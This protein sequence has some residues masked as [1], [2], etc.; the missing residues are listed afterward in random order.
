MNSCLHFDPPNGD[1]NLSSKRFALVDAVRGFA[2]ISVL[3]F[4][5]QSGH[6]IDHVMRI[7]PAWLASILQHGYLGVAIFFVLSG[8]VIAHSLY[9]ADVTLLFAGRFMLRRS[10]RLDPPYWAAIILTMGSSLLSTY[11]VPGKQPPVVTAP[12]ILAH[13][14]YL[15]DILGYPDINA[16]FWT[17]CLELQFYF[18]YVLLLLVGGQN[19]VFMLVIAS[20]ISL[21]WPLGIVTDNVW[22][23]SFLPLWHCFLLGALVY[24][25]WRRPDLS[26]F[27]GVFIAL[28]AAGSAYRHNGFSLV[29]VATAAIL[30]LSATTNQIYTIV[31]WRWLQFV[32]AISYSL[33][34]SHNFV[35]GASFRIGSFFLTEKTIA[36]EIMWSAVAVTVCVAAA[37]AL[38][39]W[40]EQP[41]IAL[42]QRLGNRAPMNP[43]KG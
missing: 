23:V 33:Y 40:V 24:W 29:C 1:P 43:A 37:Y 2:A 19:P 31:R 9:R 17:L 25:A 30:S 32:G 6:H 22:A 18:V 12:Q 28:V 34:L 5:L 3:L 20:I 14:F 26:L 27:C 15:Q 11:L 13:V 35:T 39:R 8:F 42:S 7:L 41:S 21:A 36:T 38:W 16:V 4:H 10:L